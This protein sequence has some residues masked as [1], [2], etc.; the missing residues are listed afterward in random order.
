[1]T[2]ESIK[3]RAETLLEQKAITNSE[4]LNLYWD[5]IRLLEQGRLRVAEQ[6][7]GRWVTH[8]WI[9]QVILLGFKYGELHTINEF[10]TYCYFDK[11]TV[12]PRVFSLEDQI[13]LVPGGSSVRVGAY[14]AP[15]TVIMP[16]SYI[17]VGTYLDQGVMVDSHVL[18]GS[19]A[20]IGKNVHLSAAVQ[21]GGVL[22][23]IGSSPVIIEDQVFIGGHAGIYEGVIVKTGAVIGS[24]VTLT[25]SM[26]VFDAVHDCFL[27][28]NDEE[29]PLIIPE[30]AVVVSGTRPITQ[31]AGKAQ[32]IQIYCP[33]IIKYRDHKT[34]RAT[35][36]ESLLR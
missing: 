23:P 13:R 20:Q 1:M 19:C 4:A 25:G 12:V 34:D 2:I 30:N 29:A 15:G 32:Q 6:I 26:Q 35:Q 9:K 3:L 22:E 11:T 18:V 36:L 33:V 14:L 10:S 21:I 17:N 8:R 28:K 24:G 5:T 27:R 16:P 31:G 7:D